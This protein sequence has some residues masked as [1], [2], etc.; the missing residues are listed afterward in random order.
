MLGRP[1][2]VFRRSPDV[3]YHEWDYSSLGVNVIF[4]GHARC[5]ALLFTSPSDPLLN[6]VDL[7]R[8]G[9]SAAW[10]SLRSLDPGAALE[11]ESLTSRALGLSIYA[12]S[13]FDDE[14]AEPAHSVLVF[15]PGRY[16]V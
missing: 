5:V 1:D 13:M 10:Q 2:R 3:P 14:P 15:L 4:D 8:V 16:H 11:E 7:L 9:A 12:P 6:G